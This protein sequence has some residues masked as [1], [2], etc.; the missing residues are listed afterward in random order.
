MD[1]LIVIGYRFNDRLHKVWMHIW[2]NIGCR[3]KSPSM[4]CIGEYKCSK[5]RRVFTIKFCCSLIKLKRQRGV[6]VFRPDITA[7]ATKSP[8]GVGDFQ[9]VQ[10]MRRHPTVVMLI[11]PVL[12]FV[13]LLAHRLLPRLLLVGSES[14]EGQHA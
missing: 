10:H 9:V 13:I 8:D 4:I 1:R 11:G 7:R 5:M 12:S 14:Q 2:V 3:A 6:R